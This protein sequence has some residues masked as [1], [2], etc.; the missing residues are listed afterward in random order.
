MERYQ[1]GRRHTI[2][3][4]YAYETASQ[5]HVV[6]WGYLIPVMGTGNTSKIGRVR[7]S[8]ESATIYLNVNL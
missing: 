4:Y 6:E 3:S 7:N 8:T 5:K 1:Y 2:F